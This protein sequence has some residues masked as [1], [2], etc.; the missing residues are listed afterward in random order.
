M[1]RLFAVLLLVASSAV[2]QIN[3][4]SVTGTVTDPTG[5]AVPGATSGGSW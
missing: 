1:K 4:T 5:A 3:V 2:A